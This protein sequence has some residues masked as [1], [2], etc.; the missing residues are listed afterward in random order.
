MKNHI[1]KTLLLIYAY[2][3]TFAPGLENENSSL[4]Q[5]SS[6]ATN[7]NT[8]LSLMQTNNTAT[9]ETIDLKPLRAELRESNGVWKKQHSDLCAKIILKEQTISE[10]QSLFFSVGVYGTNLNEI[11]HK[12]QDC[13]N[14]YLTFAGIHVDY[15]N[16]ELPIETNLSPDFFAEVNKCREEFVLKKFEQNLEENN[17]IWELRHS[18]FCYENFLNPCCRLESGIFTYLDKIIPIA[19][20][21]EFLK[22]LTNLYLIF[23]GRKFQSQKDFSQRLANKN[24]HNKT[25]IVDIQNFYQSYFEKQDQEKKTQNS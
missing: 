18:E 12:L 6:L 17:N 11:K 4:A 20:L 2:N 16:T 14:S 13:A 15:F 21:N 22:N 8:N 23:A 24:E 5:A 3:Y 7:E 1:L 9:S 19:T 10:F 25:T